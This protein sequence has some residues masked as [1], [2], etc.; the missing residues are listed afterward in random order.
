MMYHGLKN[1]TEITENILLQLERTFGSG[2][3]L[4]LKSHDI[5]PGQPDLHV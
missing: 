4:L 3:N 5:H 2:C 1:L